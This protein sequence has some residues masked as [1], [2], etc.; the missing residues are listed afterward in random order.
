[1]PETSIIVRTY[2]EEKHLGNLLE[3]IKKQDHQDYKIIIVDSGSRDRTLE[4]AKKFETK[5][6]EIESRDFTFG[7]SLNLGCKEARGKY[8]VFAS[9]HVLPVDSQWLAHLIAP[10]KDEKVAMVYGRHAAHSKSKFSERMDF[11]KIFGSKSIS[12]QVPITYANNANAAI[13]KS[14]W[15][16]KPFDEYLF[17]LEDIEWAKHMT[18]NGYSVHYEPKAVIYHI[19]DEMWHQIFNRYRREAVAASRIGLKHPPQARIS[20]FWLVW[21][22]VKDVSFSFPNWAPNRINEILKFRYYQW[23]GSRDGWFNGKHLDLNKDRQ[24][25]FFTDSNREAVL[26]ENRN[27]ARLRKVVLP[28]MKPGDILIE[29]DYV[30]VCRTDIEILEGTLGYYRD[31]LANYP[32]VPGHEFSGTVVKVGANNRFRERFKVGERVLGEC[33]L[34][35]GEHGE[36]REVGV[37]NHDGA[38]GKFVIIPGSHVHHIPEGIDQKNAVLTEPLAVALRALRRIENRIKKDSNIAVIGAGPLG[39][40]CAQVLTHEG[41]KVTVFDKNEKRLELLKDKVLDTK[42]EVNGLEKFDILIEITG[43][44]QVLEEVLKQSGFDKT[45]LLL[46]FPYGDMNYNFEDL[47]GQEKVIVGSVGAEEIDFSSA[48][49]LLP[50]LDLTEFTK[51]VLPLSEFEKAWQLQRSGDYLKILLKPL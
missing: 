5:I 41:H 14:L 36:R 37:I 4:I 3:A 6:I 11:R 9:A 27:K 15:F 51:K 49:N 8:L 10:F 29:V 48:L 43:S 17:G 42:T 13:R 28:E 44:K 46:G 20:H 45:I 30:G 19:H 1:M 50:K 22:I 34:S 32:I 21:V 26:I 47:I 24:E 23:K 40:L 31:G 18:H 39:N 35:R 2:N 7:Y 16:Q 12:S 33:I 25:V 38:Y